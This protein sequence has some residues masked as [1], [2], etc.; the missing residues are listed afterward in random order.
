MGR[1][2]GDFNSAVAC[3]LRY[4]LRLAEIGVHA[5][6]GL[7]GAGSGPIAAPRRNRKDGEIRGR[8]GDTLITG[9]RLLL[10]SYFD[11]G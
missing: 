1:V 3:V 4:L 7:D 10:F 8:C 11:D 6:P 9:T 5:T 2:C